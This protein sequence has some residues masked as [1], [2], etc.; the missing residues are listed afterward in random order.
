LSE[1]GHV[2]TWAVLPFGVLALLLAACRTADAPVGSAV[3]RAAIVWAGLAAVSAEGLGLFGAIGRPG[4]VA[5]WLVA[6]LAVATRCRSW[7]RPKVPSRT[8][9]GTWLGVAVLVGLVTV[10]ALLAPPNTWDSMT[11]HMARVMHWQQQGSL[12]DYPT[13][14][15]RQLASN[16]L[17]EIL[18][19]HFQ[20]LA[21][22]DRCA[23]LVQ[24]LAYAGSAVVAAALARRLGGGDRE[25]GLAAL[26]VATLPMAILQGSSTQNDLTAAFFLL[27]AAERLLAWR[28]GGRSRQALEFAGAVGLA[29]L[30]KG[31]AYF[32]AAPLVAMA[33]WWLL[34]GRDRRGPAARLALG[35]AMAL[36]ALVLNA[37][38]WQRN[39][40]AFGTPLGPQY[41]VATEEI[42]S[43]ALASN[44]LRGL[45][46]NLA[47]PV[48]ALNEAVVTAVTALHA[49][50]G[51]DVND[52]RLTFPQTRFELTRSVLD[53]N[54]AGNPL[55]LGLIVLALVLALP[56]RNRAVAVFGALVLAGGLLFCLG[57]RW[58]PWITRLQLP[59]FVLAMAPVAVLLGE[60]LSGRILGPGAA[61][62]L[63][64]ALPW[65][66]MNQ[67]RPLYGEPTRSFAHHLS[68]DIWRA[69]RGDQIFAM[70]PALEPAVQAAVA[71]IRDRTGSGVGLV[72]GGD[73]WEYPF[74]V[75]INGDRSRPPVRIEHVCAGAVGDFAPRAVLLLGPPAPERLVCEGL[76]FDR[77]VTFPATEDTANPSGVA[78]YQRGSD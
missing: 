9:L 15:V 41:G 32:F 4:L 46:S 65:A 17:A 10:T 26:L 51:R 6:A 16:P 49:L 22:D 14:I 38:H 44:L 36:V 64:M 52:P 28:D 5:F 50:V 2:I 7:P 72:L 30:T 62:L 60:R 39:L 34:R 57:L 29:L 54:Q 42:G 3:A 59:F 68:P 74:W 63:V 76:R 77:T 55:H 12:A 25:A 56:V 24:T 61:V 78:V 21:G 58:Q 73:S 13:A 75:L 69:D 18:I 40:T 45:A 11:Y 19:L 20:V 53:E 8:G 1:S 47:S 23:N 66:I 27:A 33:G 70:R 43:G 48:T 35:L 67:A 37:G 31:T 71:A